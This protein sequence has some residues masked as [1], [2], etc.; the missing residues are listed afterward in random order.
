MLMQKVYFTATYLGYLKIYVK[1]KLH[2][3]F[4]QRKI[5]EIKGCE[6]CMN[7]K[8]DSPRK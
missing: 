4:L 3:F 2:I 8:A 6:G 5:F 1:T 7:W